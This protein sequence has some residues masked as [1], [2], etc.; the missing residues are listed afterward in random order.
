MGQILEYLETLRDDVVGLLPFDVDD[1]ADPARI[2]YW[3]S[4][5][6]CFCGSPGIVMRRISSGRLVF[7]FSDGG[8]DPEQNRPDLLRDR[9]LST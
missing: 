3:G 5:S 1:E 7:P 9:W 6:P 4:Y 8:G 2:F